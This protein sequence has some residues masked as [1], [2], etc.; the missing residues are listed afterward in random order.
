MPLF[1]KQSRVARSEKERPRTLKARRLRLAK[2]RHVQAE[3]SR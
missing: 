2:W 1:D 3:E